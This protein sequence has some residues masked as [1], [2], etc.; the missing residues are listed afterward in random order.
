MNPKKKTT[1]KAKTKAKKTPKDTIQVSKEKMINIIAKGLGWVAKGKSIQPEVLVR[2]EKEGLTFGEMIGISA[3]NIGD[4]KAEYF[5]DYN[6]QETAEVLFTE[7]HLEKIK[8]IRSKSVQLK[9]KK[10]EMKIIF[11]SPSGKEKYPVDFKNK[12]YGE[13]DLDLDDVHAEIMPTEIKSGDKT[14]KFI[15]MDSIEERSRLTEEDKDYYDDDDGYY[16]VFVYVR[17]PKSEL[18]GLPKSDSLI[19]KKVDRIETGKRAVPC[20]QLET[21]VKLEKKSSYSRDLSE[22]EFIKWHDPTKFEVRVDRS[23]FDKSLAQLTDPIAIV[24]TEDFMVISNIEEDHWLA[25][26]IGY[27]ELGAD[28]V[29][30]EDETEDLDETIDEVQSKEVKETEEEE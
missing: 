11:L 27:A 14:V 9:I 26:Q 7:E 18:L 15:N 20:I 28:P 22:I 2:F 25:Y 23:H 12:V 29:D 3:G 1:R 16:P 30:I 19:F 13:D 10:S 6:I 4:Y 5:G 8:F 24:F 21:L 17:L